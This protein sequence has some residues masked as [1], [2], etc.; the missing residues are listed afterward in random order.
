MVKNFF[1][2]T[3][4]EFQIWTNKK[5]RFYFDFWYRE[6]GVFKYYIECGFFAI[7]WKVYK[8]E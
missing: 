4:H 2:D 3:K 8:G 6:I 7:A 5:P 1:S